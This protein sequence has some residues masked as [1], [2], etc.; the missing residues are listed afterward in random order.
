M[1]LYLGRKV[2]TLGTRSGE[3]AGWN[4]GLAQGSRAT[5]IVIAGLDPAIQKNAR[6]SS[7]SSSFD[8]IAGSRPAMTIRE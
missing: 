8:W 2:K 5:S 4:K 6:S 3:D 7:A 1:F